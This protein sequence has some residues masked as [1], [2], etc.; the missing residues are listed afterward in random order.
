MIAKRAPKRAEFYRDYTAMVEDEA[1]G[2]Y[3][4]KRADPGAHLV[5][6]MTARMQTPQFFARLLMLQPD[7]RARLWEQ[8]RT[9]DGDLLQTFAAA[10]SALGL[11]R[12]HEA[13]ERTIR[14][15]LSSLSQ[16]HAARARSSSWCGFA[17][18]MSASFE[19]LHR[20]RNAARA[21]PTPC[22]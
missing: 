8:L 12:D 1:A 7:C 21:Q 19:Y 10:A 4:Y 22:S 16:P 14:E 2:N 15:Y 20:L 18:F 17:A 5:F 6:V 11:L 13:A 3:V 9:V